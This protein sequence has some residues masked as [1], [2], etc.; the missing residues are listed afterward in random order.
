MDYR[1]DIDG[2]R[3]FA[4]VSVL[5]YHLS[6]QLLP[7]GFTGV[8]IFF[9]ISGFLITR[10]LRSDIEQNRFSLARFYSRRIR[11]IFPALFTVLFATFIFA[12]IAL[13]PNAYSRFMEEFRFASLQISNFTFSKELDYFAPGNEL[14]LLLHTWSLGV[15]EQFYLFWPLLLFTGFHLFKKKYWYVISGVILSS[16]LLSDYFCRESPQQAFYL[17]HSRAWELGIG[18]ILTFLPTGSLQMKWLNSILASTGFVF[19]ILGFT[20]LNQYMPFPGRNGL[21]PV[22]GAALLIYTGGRQ[23]TIVAPFLANRI[24]VFIGKISYSVYLW[25]W[26]LIISYKISTGKEIDIISGSVI[27]A[28]TCLLATVSYYFVEQ[29]FRRK[30]DEPHQNAPKPKLQLLTCTVALAMLACL[31]FSYLFEK[32][33]KSTLLAI[34]IRGIESPSNFESED[35]TIYWRTDRQGFEEERSLDL[36]YVDFI[37]TDDVYH[38]IFEL[39]PIYSIDSIRIDPLR[40][41]GVI[42]ILQIQVTSGLLART[43]TFSDVSW[44]AQSTVGASDNLEFSLVNGKLQI[45]SHSTDPYFLLF[46]KFPHFYETESLLLAVM[47]IGCFLFAAFSCTHRGQMHMAVVSY[48]LALICFSITISFRGQF[49]STSSWRFIEHE[50]PEYWREAMAK[51]DLH[52]LNSNGAAQVVLWGDSH[53]RNYGDSVSR[54]TNEKDLTLKLIYKPACPPVAINQDEISALLDIAYTNYTVCFDHNEE[55]LATIENDDQIE[56]VFLAMRYEYYL[57]HPSML[58]RAVL[59]AQVPF[60]REEYFRHS[61]NY[62]IERLK[63]AGKKIV[64]L[65][66]VPVLREK[67]D[68]CIKRNQTLLTYILKLKPGCDV[69]DEF[70]D[71]ILR[72]GRTMFEQTTIENPSVYY[73]KPEKYV[74]S[75]F[76]EGGALKYHDNNHLNSYGAE[77]LVPSFTKELKTF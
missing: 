10:L 70:S 50:S 57:N 15:E 21:L 34:K 60:S 28:V 14:S 31:V 44:I 38:F 17:L 63:Q 49:S 4:V 25:H 69:N 53:V 6:P 54:W 13:E 12:L 18:G 59:E 55:T 43:K 46:A 7:G 73:F 19:I 8:D 16:F 51:T 27:A 68:I 22:L 67:P 1:R 24:C 20:K 33:E 48:G 62:T 36:D 65:G 52:A 47:A 41:E 37:D 45:Q 26:P 11:R 9:V 66:Q 64:L 32:N 58:F 56:Y 42:E 29:P 76:G 75:I 77:L 72:L 74:S 40:H 23:K 71:E 2:L 5:L 30:S 3:C 39:P 35:V 61:F